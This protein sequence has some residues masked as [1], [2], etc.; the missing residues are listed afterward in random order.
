MGVA[1]YRELDQILQRTHTSRFSELGHPDKAAK[2]R[3]RLDD[4]QVRNVGIELMV[5]KPV[6]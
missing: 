2:N 4:R 3:H 6:A 5:A 1:H